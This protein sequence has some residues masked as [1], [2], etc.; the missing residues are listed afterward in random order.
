MCFIKLLIVHKSQ[1]HPIKKFMMAL[2]PASQHELFKLK[3]GEDLQDSG[4]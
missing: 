3:S 1:A 2:S 4:T